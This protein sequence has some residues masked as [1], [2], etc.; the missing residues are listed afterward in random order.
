MYFALFSEKEQYWSRVAHRFCSGSTTYRDQP[1]HLYDAYTGEIRATYRPYNRLDE[2]ESPATVCFANNGRQIIAGG[3]RTDRMLH[4]FDL[5]RPG[6]ETA[7]VLKLGKTRR[8]KDGQKGL[9]SA[10]SVASTQQNLLAVGTYSPGSIYLY[11]VR[12]QTTPV[13]ELVVDGSCVVGHGKSHSRKRKHFVDP[14]DGTDSLNFSAAK[15]QWY[16]SRARGGVT[17][18][19]FSPDCQYLLSSSR[20]SN[21]V[22]QWDLR[23]LSS[24]SFCPGVAS[25]ET[26]S[27]TNQRLGFAFDGE[28]RLVVGGQ[29]KCVRVYTLNGTVSLVAKFD[30]FGDAVN[31]VSLHDFEGKKLMATAV[32]SRKFPSDEDW[33]LDVVDDSSNGWLSLSR[34]SA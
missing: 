33:D 29:D 23:R 22:L 17:Q 6:R 18:V 32:G 28:D 9:V 20:R 1:I 30:D 21:A 26:C 31:G 13:A 5:N 4:V 34:I 8:S 10:L 19:E 16:Q 2:M 7:I 27:D 3:F 15:V 11:D 25:Y 14:D 12:T 24:S